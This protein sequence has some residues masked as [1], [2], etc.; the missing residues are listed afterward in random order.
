MGSLVVLTWTLLSGWSKTSLFPKRVVQ[1]VDLSSWCFLHVSSSACIAAS[2][3][4]ASLKQIHEKSDQFLISKQ[5]QFTR[6]SGT[7]MG[8]GEKGIHGQE[9]GEGTEVSFTTMG[10]PFSWRCTRKPLSNHKHSLTGLSQKVQSSPNS[11]YRVCV[12]LSSSEKLK[13]KT[14]KPLS[15]LRMEFK[16]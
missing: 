6:K 13:F 15:P 5:I 2:A 4:Q 7:G 12:V 1:I 3:S 8:V 10:Q 9:Q 11:C 16:Y 14:G